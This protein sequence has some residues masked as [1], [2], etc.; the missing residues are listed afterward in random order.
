MIERFYLGTHQPHWLERTRIPLF[1]SH[2]RLRRMCNLPCAI[3][4]W[5][6]DSGGFTELSMH[7]RWE[8]TPAEYADAVQLYEHEVGNLDW[9]A[10]QDWMCEPFMLAKTGLTVRDHQRRTVE[11]YGEL[12]GMAPRLPF[13]P[14]LQGWCLAD[15]HR[16]V[17][18]YDRAGIDLRAAPVVGLGSVCRRQATSEIG[19]I[20]QSLASLGLNLHGF[21]VKT[22]G[23]ARYAEHLVSA[24]SMA[25][26]YEARRGE[27]LTGCLHRNCANCLRYAQVWLDRVMQR[28]PV[29]VA[30]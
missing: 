28:L 7:G 27:P 9:A 22:A 16:C 25:W 1:V 14:V 13:F 26:S 20:V 5:A 19:E 15:Y 8:T 24:D 6:L 10:P 11:N 29:G 2:R 12:R 21:G 23:L 18:M 17:E 30:A 4:P 3:G